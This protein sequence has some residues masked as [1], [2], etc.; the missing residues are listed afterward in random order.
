MDLHWQYGTGCGRQEIDKN[1]TDS[2]SSK[3]KNVFL[4]PLEFLKTFRKSNQ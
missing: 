2:D 1:N 4:P 3:I